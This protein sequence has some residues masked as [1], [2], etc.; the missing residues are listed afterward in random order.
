MHVVVTGASSGIGEALAREF[1]R[2]GAELTLVARRRELLEKLAAS[3]PT[4]TRVLDRDLS[5]PPRAPALLA[6]AEAAL[7]PVDVLINNAG[8]QVVAP[9]A[10]TDVERAEASLKLNLL[11]PLRLAHAVLPGML[12]R[13]R[14]TIVNI[15]SLAALAPTPGMTWYNAGKGGLGAASEALRGELRR[16]GVHVVTVYPGPVD[17]AMARAGIEAYGQGSL[18]ARIPIGTPEVLAQRVRRAVEQRQARVVYPR[19]YALARW[20][21]ITTRVFMDLF[22]PPP[23]HLP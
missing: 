17:S 13:G 20:F 12:A 4:R 23:K 5:D 19:V 16:S 9:T 11:T 21:P 8:A 10:H 7:G 1:A 15:A 6:E 14:G 22:T 2:A 3:L 18:A